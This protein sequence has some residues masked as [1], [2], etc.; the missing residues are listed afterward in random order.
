MSIPP[1]VGASVIGTA[2]GDALGLPMEGMTPRRAKAMFRGPLR[3]RFIFGRGM[4]SDDTE[5]TWMVLQSLQEFPND[6]NGFQH[7]LARRLKLWLLMVP[8][9]AGLATVKSTL[10]LLVGVPPSR[11]GV[12]SAGNGAAMRAAVIGAWFCDDDQKR[13]QFVEAA[14]VITHRD[15]R[16]IQG[17]QLVA[18]AAA[19]SACADMKL[20]ECKSK[21]FTFHPAWQEDL[22]LS[23][24]VSGYVVPTVR[25]ALDAWRQH[26]T[27]YQAAVSEVIT[28][29][30]DTDTVAAIV[31]GIV[32]ARVGTEGIPQAWRD[33]LWEWPRG[34]KWMRQPGGYAWPLIPLRN[35]VFLF[36][37][38]FHGFRRLLPPY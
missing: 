36:T 15:E 10:R 12:P 14:S 28:L 34:L 24:G 37:V 17:A 3:H 1:S 6:P 8:A 5:H 27:D 2:V 25:V 23:K 31:G 35:A 22:D 11:S 21:N 33:G 7:A 13:V 26:P 30:G 38:L 19:A 18:L 29:G 16:A 9:G 20:F 32:G 4:V